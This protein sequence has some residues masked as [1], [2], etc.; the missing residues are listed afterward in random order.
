M[1]RRDT[2]YPLADLH[3]HLDGSLRV[4]TV[5]EL[6]ARKGI[7]IPDLFPQ[8]DSI[9]LQLGEIGKWNALEIRVVGKTFDKLLSI[10]IFVTGV[11]GLHIKPLGR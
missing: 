7:P 11:I 9:A 2:E 8:K 3:R 6:A 1:S 4:S 10:Q 5:E